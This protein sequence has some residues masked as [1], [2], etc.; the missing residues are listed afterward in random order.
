MQHSV[1]FSVQKLSPRVSL[2]AEEKE[3][4]PHS[5]EDDLKHPAILLGATSCQLT[6]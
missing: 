5:Y 1:V 2:S 6:E 4:H 3:C